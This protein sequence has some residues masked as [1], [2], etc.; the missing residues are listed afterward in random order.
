MYKKDHLQKK[1]KA[2]DKLFSDDNAEQILR[3]MVSVFKQS[4]T[5]RKQVLN[6]LEYIE[7]KCVAVLDQLQ[8]FEPF[9]GVFEEHQEKILDEKNKE[10]IKEYGKANVDF[11]MMEKEHLKE[12]KERFGI[13]NIRIQGWH[14]DKNSYHSKVWNEKENC[15]HAFI[16]WM[17]KK[18]GQLR[19]EH[20]S[21]PIW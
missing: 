7:D 8:K 20:R 19:F 1:V 16:T 14:F 21:H 18:N 2:D 9:K 17:T 3:E 10:K 12:I 6:D 15:Q 13:E 11:V 4:A 5:L